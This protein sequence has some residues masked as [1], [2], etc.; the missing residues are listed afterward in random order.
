MADRGWVEV[1][2]LSPLRHWCRREEA[3][4][5]HVEVAAWPPR[6]R[7][8]EGVGPGV[9]RRDGGARERHRWGIRGAHL[10]RGRV[11][12]RKV[13]WL[14]RVKMVRDGEREPRGGARAELGRGR[15]VEPER[16]RARV[17]TQVVELDRFL[18]IEGGHDCGQRRQ[19]D[20]RLDSL[21]DNNHNTKINYKT[22]TIKYIYMYTYL[23]THTFQR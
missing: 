20:K 9:E 22:T 11:R 18:E 4:P 3:L 17:T 19:L 5:T 12:E 8:R 15:G 6:D 21:H 2:F 1:Q 7:R 23:I 16:G 13:P 10:G 14:Q